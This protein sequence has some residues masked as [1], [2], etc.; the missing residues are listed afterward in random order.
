MQ[1][2]YLITCTKRKHSKRMP[3]KDLYTASEL[4]SL[5]RDFVERSLARMKAE[6]IKGG[7]FILSAK[8]HLLD[9]ER[10]I[11]P[12]DE[13][14]YDK[15]L[16][17]RQKW[18]EEVVEQ[19]MKYCYLRGFDPFQT[20]ITILAGY[21]YTEYLIPRLRHEGFQVVAPWLEE[22][23]RGLRGQWNIMRWRKKWLRQKLATL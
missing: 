12:Y 7:W 11:E 14:L 13:T 4:F 20:R 6:G 18:A 16:K 5:A 3:A 1:Q 21:V 8:H 15:T 2:L 10:E 9:P 22:K 19:L 17:Q 23:P